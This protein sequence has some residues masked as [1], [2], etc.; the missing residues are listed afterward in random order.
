MHRVAR[1]LAVVAA[2]LVIVPAAKSQVQFGFAGGANFP[3]GSISNELKTGYSAGANLW[4]GAPLIPFAV[5]VEGMYDYWKY[6]PASGEGNFR[7]IRGTANAI[8]SFAPGPV[9]PYITGGVGVYNLK[10]SAET[11]TVGAVGV[12]SEG[13]SQTK[14]GLNAGGGVLLG[15]AGFGVY[16]EATYHHVFTDGNAL[17]M[18]PV[19]VGVRFGGF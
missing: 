14:F 11:Y 4:I 19:V 2:A 7:D 5:R 15:L 6:K 18:I 13:S 1:A 3:T 16:A 17:N 9:K 8:F 10:A 12:S